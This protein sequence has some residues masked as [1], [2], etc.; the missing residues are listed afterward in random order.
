MRVDV[1]E[2]HDA[3]RDIIGV[4]REH[5]QHIRAALHRDLQPLRADELPPVTEIEPLIVL[6]LCEPLGDQP[7]EMRRVNRLELHEC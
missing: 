5:P 3:D 7:K 4:G 1:T 6:L 2:A